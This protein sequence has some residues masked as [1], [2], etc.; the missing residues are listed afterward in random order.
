MN[1][2]LIGV[3][4]GKVILGRRSCIFRGLKYRER[5]FGEYW[6]GF[7]CVCSGRL[8]G[9]VVYGYVLEIFNVRLRNLDFNFSK[10]YLFEINFI[11]FKEFFY[12]FLRKFL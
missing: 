4:E 6:W 2:F 1:W 11:V 10:S 7:G 9:Y 5:G 3:M 8:F 12:I